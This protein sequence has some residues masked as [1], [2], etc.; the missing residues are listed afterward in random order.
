MQIVWRGQKAYEQARECG[1]K[2]S[3]SVSPRVIIYISTEQEVRRVLRFAMQTGWPVRIRGG[4]QHLRGWCS[5]EDGIVLDVTGLSRM[6]RRGRK[7]LI[8]GAGARLGQVNDFLAGSGLILPLPDAAQLS[9]GGVLLGGGLSVLSRSCGLLCDRLLAARVVLS[10]GRVLVCTRRRHRDL[11]WAC[12][13]GGGGQFGVVT[14]LELRLHAGDAATFTRTLSSHFA[15]SAFDAWQRH[16]PA[17]TDRVGSTFE[18]TCRNVQLQSTLARAPNTTT[19]GWTEHYR[20]L[21]M[22]PAPTYHRWLGFFMT[23]CLPLHIVQMLARIMETAPSD[24]HIWCLALRGR[25]SRSRGGAFAHR[26]ALYYIEPGAEWSRGEENVR[27]CEWVRMVATLLQPFASGGYV[28]VPDE[29]RCDWRQHYYGAHAQ[30]LQS[31]KRK[32]DPHNLFSNPQGLDVHPSH[33]GYASRVHDKA[34]QKGIGD[35]LL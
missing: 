26:K 11:F 24:A 30:R 14:Q 12:R 15:A 20:A 21:N 27:M 16:S 4:G 33:R 10:T 13:G 2:L 3:D 34:A 31:I 25:I 28:N 32:Y 9:I 8:V 22:N 17:H 23:R 7:R 6:E 35:H 5:V 1:D 29:L 18:W 19:R